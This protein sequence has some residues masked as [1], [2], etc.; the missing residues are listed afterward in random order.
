MPPSPSL[1]FVFL[2]LKNVLDV[3]EK[4]LFVS[5]KGHKQAV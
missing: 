3:L 4:G 2:F 5:E 1:P